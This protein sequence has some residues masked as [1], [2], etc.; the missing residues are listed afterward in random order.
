[1]VPPSPKATARP[2]EALAEAG[3]CLLR[4]LRHLDA[5]LPQALVILLAGVLHH[6]PIGPH[7][8][9]PGVVP[10]P[11]EGF[12]I[13]DDHF[14][15]DVTEIGPREPLN[16]VELFAVRMTDRVEAGLAVEIHRV[17]DERVAF[18]VADRVA[19]P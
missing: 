19:E 9:G 5:A 11:G 14:V 12:R 18:P 16:Q 7:G 4:V 1:A 17:D 3:A 15:V 10:R 6:F 2:A 13:F 8:E